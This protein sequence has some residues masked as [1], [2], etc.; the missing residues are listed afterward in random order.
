MRM[1]FMGPPYKLD[2]ITKSH[3][4]LVYNIPDFTVISDIY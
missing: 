3:C 4:E 1:A 2:N